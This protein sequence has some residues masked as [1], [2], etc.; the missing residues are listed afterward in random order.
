MPRLRPGEVERRAGRVPHD[1]GLGDA[2]LGQRDVLAHCRQ[3][4]A[5]LLVGAVGA[6]V[7]HP[8]L[9]AA[10]RLPT[11]LQQ[12]QA[13]A[14]DQRPLRGEFLP[15]RLELSLGKTK[16]GAHLVDHSLV[17]ANLLG[18]AG[19]I[20]LHQRLAAMD[21]VANLD[22]HAPHPRRD[23]RANLALPPGNDRCRQREP[24]GDVTRADAEDLDDGWLMRGRGRGVRALGRGIGG[25]G[26]AAAA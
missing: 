11:R 15:R 12:R 6:E 7:L 8:A 20:E 14:A 2:L 25:L 24:V 3:S 1:P 21:A 17:H 18:E 9:G 10:A 16:L 13:A 22:M 26:C 5:L 23:E 4:R 19:S